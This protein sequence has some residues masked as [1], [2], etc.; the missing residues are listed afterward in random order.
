[1]TGSEILRRR[2]A[3]A[4]AFA[5][6]V[7]LTAGVSYMAG[8]RSSAADRGGRVA[9]LERRIAELEA[10]TG[11]WERGPVAS[12]P[13]FVARPGGGGYVW[14]WP[15]FPPKYPRIVTPRVSAPEP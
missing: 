15:T 8:A 5:A 10:R 3:R 6:L 4:C 7:G 1:M 9:R 14:M 11:A 2:G 13:P 12:T